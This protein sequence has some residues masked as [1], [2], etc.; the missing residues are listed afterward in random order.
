MFTTVWSII[1]R[2]ERASA[3]GNVLLVD[4]V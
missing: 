3:I 1:C 2:Y 4:D